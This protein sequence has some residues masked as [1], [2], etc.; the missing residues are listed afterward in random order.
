MRGKRV[1]KMEKENVQLMKPQNT[2]F[3]R[4]SDGRT[5]AT[6]EKEAWELVSS[7]SKWRRQDIKMIGMS[8]GTTYYK[9]VKQ[10]GPRKAEL[11]DQIVELKKV[12]DKYIKTHDRFL[13]EDLLEDDDTKVLRAKKLIA[14]TEA[15]LEPIEDELESIMKN[16]VKTATDA[17]LKAAEGNMVMP[18]N[19][20]VIVANTPD[21]KRHPNIVD[22][23]KR[24]RGL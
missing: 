2:W 18:R 21:A 19:Q 7:T 23:F 16:L 22:N 5:F 3:F 20:D 24:S 8:D 12:R 1:D 14:D 9:T 10:A 4:D 15:K 11:K 6:N 13:F 17:E